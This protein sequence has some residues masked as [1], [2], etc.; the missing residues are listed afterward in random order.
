MALY[1]QHFVRQNHDFT[2]PLREE[3]CVIAE[4]DVVPD[5]D[6]AAA[7]MDVMWKALWAQYPS[8]VC[9]YHAGNQPPNAF[10]GWRHGWSSPS[11]NGPLLRLD[12]ADQEK[13]AH[14]AR[15]RDPPPEKAQYVMTRAQAVHALQ[16]MDHAARAIRDA[17]GDAPP[18]DPAAAAGRS[19][20]PKSVTSLLR[21]FAARG[22]EPA[23]AAEVAE[24]GAG[25]YDAVYKA[26]S[27][28]FPHLFRRSGRPNK[29]SLT[30][31]GVAAAAAL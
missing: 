2:P 14:Y 27:H 18:P 13:N 26:M 25:K 21:F 17:L 3:V 8:W 30:E 29:W 10:E 20:W 5:G 12:H 31:A 4:A 23:T 7:W 24:A 22:N 11:L 1:A 15:F 16:T 28:G 19:P 9:P 6:D